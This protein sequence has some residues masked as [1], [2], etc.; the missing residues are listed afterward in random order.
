MIQ[1]SFDPH[2]LARSSDVD[3]S[4]E[5]AES[6]AEIRARQHNDILRVLTNR[7]PMTAEQI[8][9]VLGVDIWRRMS[10][11]LAAGAVERCH[12]ARGRSGRSA[13]TFRK[14]SQ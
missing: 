4:H 1:L 11:L 12:K 6:V 2:T 3:T 14:V 5:A 13:Y 7:R 9:D 10:E 8:S